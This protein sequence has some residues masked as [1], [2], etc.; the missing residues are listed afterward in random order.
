MLRAG[1]LMRITA[2]TVVFGAA[3]LLPVAASCEAA[4]VADAVGL[5]EPSLTLNWN[6][7]EPGCDLSLTG[8]V[9][10]QGQLRFS[11]QLAC[12]AAKPTVQRVGVGSAR[13]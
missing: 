4:A 3:L 9:T 6:F 5:D 11:A 2:V 1:T 13:L 7:G 10:E 8:R 12:P